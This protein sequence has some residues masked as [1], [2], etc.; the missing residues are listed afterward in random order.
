MSVCLPVSYTCLLDT[1]ARAG[2]IPSVWRDL[3]LFGCKQST[4]EPFA[5]CPCSDGTVHVVSLQGGAVTQLHCI[6]VA[7][8]LE[9]AAMCMSAGFSTDGKQLAVATSA[10]VVAV[11]CTSTWK[12]LSQLDLDQTARSCCWNIMVR[13]FSRIHS[14]SPCNTR[15]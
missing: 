9:D 15:S 5:A 4:T 7:Q 6:N 11:Y 14:A 3:A 12:V 13:C 1:L 2:D 8:D 10:R